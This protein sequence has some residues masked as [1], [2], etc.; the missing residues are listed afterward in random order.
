MRRLF[1]KLVGKRV[2]WFRFWLIRLFVGRMACLM[3][4][5]LVN[6]IDIPANGG[7]FFICGNKITSTPHNPM[8]TMRQ[9]GR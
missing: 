1:Y 3:N 2:V 5:E 8:I 7:T 9:R 6:G 4:I